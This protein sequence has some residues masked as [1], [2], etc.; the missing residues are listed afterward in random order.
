ML[1]LLRSCSTRTR[2][3]LYPP[4]SSFLPTFW[5]LTKRGLNTRPKWPWMLF[6]PNYD[7]IFG[8]AFCNCRHAYAVN[9]FQKN[10]QEHNTTH[11]PHTNFR[12]RKKT[13]TLCHLR[14][15]IIKMMPSNLH[16]VNKFQQDGQQVRCKALAWYQFSV[17]IKKIDATWIL[18]HVVV[19]NSRTNQIV[20]QTQKKF[21]N[22]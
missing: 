3:V 16:P 5:V 9:E 22:H 20:T 19:Q 12:W 4:G 1:F 17:P 14:L 15:K 2:D 10:E 7:I 6:K 11:L 21:T 13:W 8:R 18:K